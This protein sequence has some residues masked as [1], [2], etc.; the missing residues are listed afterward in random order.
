MTRYYIADLNSAQGFREITEEEY[1]SI[2]ANEETRP[3]VTPVY[4]GDMALDEVPED[5]RS[6]VEAIVNARISVYG[7]WD[8]RRIDD[9]SAMATIIGM[10][11]LDNATAE[12]TREIILQAAS[13]L[14]DQIA[15][16]APTLYNSMKYDGSLIPAGTRI[17]W[18][19]E[20]KRAASD[21]W[22]TETNNPDN[23][24]ALWESLMYRKGIRI[25]P[26][27]ITPGL[28]F[29]KGEK[30]WWGE[31]LYRSLVDNNVY[32]PEQYPANWEIET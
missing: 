30:G 19:G 2:L 27:V 3:Y 16:E 12:R 28:A 7:P 9:S 18:N 20:L 5:V 4:K 32:T 15:S 14:P 10:N 26:E 8:T 22:D 11:A 24:P 17:N 29:A 31:T 1:N 23:A 13:G 25:I 6:E 21:L